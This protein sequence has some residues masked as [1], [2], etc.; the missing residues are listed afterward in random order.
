MQAAIIIHNGMALT[1]SSCVDSLPGHDQVEEQHY[2]HAHRNVGDARIPQRHAAVI[3]WDG[4]A[5][6]STSSTAPSEHAPPGA[7]VLRLR[8]PLGPDN[9]AVDPME[10]NKRYAGLP[11]SKFMHCIYHTILVL[12]PFL[13]LAICTSWLK[14]VHE[15]APCIWRQEAGAHLYWQRMRLWKVMSVRKAAYLYTVSVM[16]ATRKVAVHT[17]AV[18]A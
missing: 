10:S 11:K 8:R 14:P 12:F 17:I 7:I 4:P 15:K 2:A 13:S 16:G 1:L 3:P 6:H 9:Q 18:S 5:P